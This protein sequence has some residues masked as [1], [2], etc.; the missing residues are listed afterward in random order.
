MQGARPPTVRQ[1]RDH[2]LA[3]LVVDV[4]VCVAYIMSSWYE[5]ITPYIY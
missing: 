4:P 3:W 2:R 5:V 1:L